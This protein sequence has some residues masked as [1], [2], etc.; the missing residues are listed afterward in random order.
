MR[1][2]SEAILPRATSSIDRWAR[3]A[4]RRASSRVIFTGAVYRSGGELA[5][6]LAMRTISCLL[7]LSL[8]AACQQTTETR[9]ET[10]GTTTVQTSTTDNTTTIPAVHVDTAEVKKDA[11]EAA[12]EAKEA[13]RTAAQKT[14]TA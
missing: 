2:I 8:A 7:I 3:A 1:V 12:A 13:A 11:S 10:V 6:Q 9:T 14:G 5:A 4:M